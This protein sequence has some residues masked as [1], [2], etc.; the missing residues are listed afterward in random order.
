VFWLTAG[1]LL[2]AKRLGRPLAGDWDFDIYIP[3]QCQELV[4]E[5]LTA[6]FKER[7]LPFK[8]NSPPRTTHEMN[9]VSLSGGEKPSVD[10]YQVKIDHSG[11][12]E[13]R[14][15]DAEWRATNFQKRKYTPRLT[16][17]TLPLVDCDLAIAGKSHK[18]KCPAQAW[19]LL[20]SWYGYVG[21]K[22]NTCSHNKQG[23][24]AN[25]LHGCKKLSLE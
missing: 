24:E 13:L 3:E 20:Q 16:S 8:V 18:L 9:V 10:M 14:T 5:A 11:C 7:S 23:E 21:A 15:R 19:K 12:I 25:K 1:T 22:P 6:A 4:Y 17:W 2:G